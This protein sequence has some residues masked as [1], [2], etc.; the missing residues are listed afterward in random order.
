MVTILLMASQP[1]FAANRVTVADSLFEQRNLNFDA[2]QLLA[3]ST[4]IIRAIEL[5]KQAVD[6]CKNPQN[7][8]EALWKC[9]RAYYFKGTYTTSDV[10]EKRDIY[11][12]GISYGER[13][14]ETYSESVE[15]NCWMGILWGYR[16]EVTGYLKA[17][18][19]G[20]AGEVKNYAEKT[21]ELDKSYLDGGGYRMLGYLHFKVPNIPF[22]LG[23]PSKKKAQKLLEKAHKIAPDNLLNKLYLA[24]V[25]LDSGQTEA[26]K[27]L[28]LDII[29]TE[30]LVHDIAVDKNA[31]K[32]ARELLEKYNLNSKER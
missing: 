4:I 26:G 2:E 17:A 9:L 16:G 15:F 31:K 10:S 14:A 30:T 20:I 25:Y 11:E 28:L 3:D 27:E 7:R 19:E 5:Y 21:I 22:V 12:E 1:G 29:N 23:W 18:R 8:L 6:S 13:Y 24:E 32:M